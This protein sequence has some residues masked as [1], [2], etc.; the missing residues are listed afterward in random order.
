MDEDNNTIVYEFIDKNT[1]QIDRI[2]IVTDLKHG[3]DKTMRDL[4]FKRHQFCIFHFKLGISKI[5]REY[6]R[7]LRIEQIQILKKTLENPSK[8]IH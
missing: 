6:L 8:K 1:K 7:D 4:K 2:G 5:I 3:Y